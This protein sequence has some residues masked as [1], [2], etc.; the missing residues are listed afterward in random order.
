MSLFLKMK[1]MVLIYWE[2]YVGEYMKTILTRAIPKN[3]FI[4]LFNI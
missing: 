1:T 3:L 2:A 4:Y